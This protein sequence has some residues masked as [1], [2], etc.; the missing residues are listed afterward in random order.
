MRLKAL[1]ARL[2][3][4]ETRHGP[5]QFAH[6]TYEEA[7]QALFDRLHRMVDAAGGIDELM[8]EWDV[9]TDLEP[10]ALIAQ[11]RSCERDVRVSYLEMEA[12]LCPRP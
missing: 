4:L 6:L 12:R 2:V 11:I 9:E 5:G 10:L 3:R 1:E 7:E 8:A